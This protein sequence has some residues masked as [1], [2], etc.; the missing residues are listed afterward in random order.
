MKLFATTKR[1]SRRLA[2]AYAVLMISAINQRYGTPEITSA[3]EVYS[4]EPHQRCGKCG[5][6]VKLGTQIREALRR[7]TGPKVWVHLRCP[8]ILDDITWFRTR[9]FDC[10]IGSVSNA[11]S[12]NCVRC[13]KNQEGKTLLQVLR[14]PEPFIDYVCKE[15]VRT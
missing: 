8:Y 10:V 15:C 2:D 1:A 7:G 11:R 3:R 12:Q 14:F 13:G 9:E 5:L 6:S 4:T